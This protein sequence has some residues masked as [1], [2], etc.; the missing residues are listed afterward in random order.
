MRH[1][2]GLGRLAWE[3]GDYEHAAEF[4][5]EAIPFFEMVGDLR[6]IAVSSNGVGRAAVLLQRPQEALPYLSRSLTLAQ[7]LSD[8]HE[9][10]LAIEG[11]ALVALQDDD[12][13]RTA[14]LLAGWVKMPGERDCFARFEKDWIYN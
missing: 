7:T 14:R 1:L 4:F 10:S 3:D 13:E 12:P 5:G 8:Q 9:A 11:L 2:F 6:G